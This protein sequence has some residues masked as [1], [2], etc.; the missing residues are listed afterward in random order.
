MLTSFRKIFPYLIVLTLAAEARELSAQCV[1]NLNQSSD[2]GD[3]IRL[4]GE[5]ISNAQLND[6][7]GYWATCS[8]YGRG[9]P[10][11]STTSTSANVF[12]AITYFVGQG[13]SCGVTI[14]DSPTSIRITLWST[15]KTPSGQTV[16]CNVTDTLAHELGHVLDLGNSSCQGYVMGPPPLTSQN[17]QLVN[18]TRSVQSDECSAA[19]NYWTTTNDNG[20]DPGN[21]NPPPCV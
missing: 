11:F 14:H 9:F 21:N 15:T 4:S 16:T 7:A 19:N 12:V 5:G 20:G 17:G 13:Q 18:G 8:S 10:S 2:T 3:V 1:G 6:A